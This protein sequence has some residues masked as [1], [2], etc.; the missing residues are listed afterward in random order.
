MIK[1][2]KEYRGRV[3]QGKE[4]GGRGIQGDDNMIVRE[5]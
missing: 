5:G 2:I 1:V 4:C 3:I